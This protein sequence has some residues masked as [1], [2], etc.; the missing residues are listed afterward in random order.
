[1]FKLGYPLD[2]LDN[3]K[4]DKNKLWD[5]KKYEEI[6]NKVMKY[7]ANGQE[8]PKEYIDYMLEVKKIKEEHGLL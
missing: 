4:L 2:E 1:M 7:Y 5:N 3:K 8:P 6:A